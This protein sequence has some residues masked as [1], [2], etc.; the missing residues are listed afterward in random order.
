MAYALLHRYSNLR[1][2]LERLPA[3]GRHRRFEQLAV[4]LV[5]RCPESLARRRAHR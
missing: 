3:A 1:W 4:T 5:A 2:Y